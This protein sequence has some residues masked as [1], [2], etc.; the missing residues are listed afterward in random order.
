MNHDKLTTRS[1]RHQALDAFILVL[2]PE[3]GGRISYASESILSLLGYNHRR[4]LVPSPA[5]AISQDTGFQ[6]VEHQSQ[7]PETTE[8]Q[9]SIYDLVHEQDH[10]CVRSLLHRSEK[11]EDLVLG[12]FLSAKVHMK[13]NRSFPLTFEEIRL[14]G[15]FSQMTPKQ[16]SV[17]DQVNGKRKFVSIGRLLRPKFLK[18]LRLIPTLDMMHLNKEFASRHSLEWKFLF[19]D[20]RASSLIGYM[21]F[22]V[23]GT[24]GY[25]YYHWDD[26]SLVVA[27]HEQ[28]MLRGEGTSQQYR[29]LTKGQ[30]W[31]WLRT[32][33][34][35]TYHQWNS[36]PE[37]I[38]CTHTIT[39]LDEESEAQQSRRMDAEVPAMT[40]ACRPSDQMA[41]GLM[42]QRI[43]EEHP[44]V[45]RET[46]LQATPVTEEFMD[47]PMASSSSSCGTSDS[48]NLS[49]GPV[50]QTP[51]PNRSQQSLKRRFHRSLQ[52]QNHISRPDISYPETL[53][54][55]DSTHFL[56]PSS[57]SSGYTSRTTSSSEQSDHS[58]S[59]QK[60]ERIHHH[61]HHNDNGLSLPS[62]SVNSLITQNP[63]SSYCD[64]VTGTPTG[65]SLGLVDQSQAQTILRKKHF[66][67]QA[68]IQQQ[69]E[70][71]RRMEEQL[72]D[73]QYGVSMDQES[74]GNVD[75]CRQRSSDLLQDMVT[76]GLA[77]E[78]NPIPDEAA[79]CHQPLTHTQQSLT[80]LNLDFN[81]GGAGN[82][83]VHVT[84]DFEGKASVIHQHHSSPSY[85][86]VDHH[87]HHHHPLHHE[88][89]HHHQLQAQ[90][91]EVQQE[92]SLEAQGILCHDA[93]MSASIATT[94][95][96][97]PHLMFAWNN[98]GSA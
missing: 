34:Y 70:E 31:I 57:M 61:H 87:P 91:E 26:L 10:F 85:H 35:I 64:P 28:L 29:F 75:A 23:L 18:E 22:E 95:A 32:R 79:A 53:T 7:E 78:P 97:D 36:K 82:R 9:S 71:L 77:Y 76:G 11:R 38:V 58:C 27:G 39:G 93:V 81:A 20:H 55:V 33:S 16:H 44:G 37:F 62:E 46:V 94:A 21:P 59:D 68:H 83:P 60:Y 41:Q 15:S 4:F 48:R 80:Y 52:Q 30:Q 13:K 69:Q 88:Q 47:V 12:S 19:L 92:S 74:S 43:I 96:G 90:E 84:P 98:S 51:H 8:Q 5:A 65:H 49:D 42:H 14:L 17:E 3:S 24:S 40:S 73:S 50:M 1:I 72:F 56:A 86:M 2:N 66:L 67:L 89:Q 45:V 63:S 54:N 6:S 25:D